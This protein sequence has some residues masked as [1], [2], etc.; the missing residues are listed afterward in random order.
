MN[1]DVSIQA[2]KVVLA[3][4]DEGKINHLIYFPNH[5]IIDAKNNYTITKQEALAMVYTLKKFHHYLLAT[6]FFYF[7][8][9]EAL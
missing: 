7:T 8:N 3:Q 6:I 9:H 4:L 5:K 1:I 2:I